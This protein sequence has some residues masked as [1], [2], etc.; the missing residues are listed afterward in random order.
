[1]KFS[2]PPIGSSFKSLM[3][4][5][6]PLMALAGFGG[7][8]VGTGALG[9]QFIMEPKSIAWL[10]DYLPDHLQ[11]PLSPWDRPHTLEDI[12]KNLEKGDLKLGEWIELSGGDRMTTVSQPRFNCISAC[13]RIIE[14][15]IY[16]RSKAHGP[17][18]NLPHFRMIA[19]VSIPSSDDRVILDSLQAANTAGLEIEED[20]PLD[21]LEKLET[22]ENQKGIWLNLLGKRNQGDHSVSYGQLFHYDSDRAKLTALIQWASPATMPLQWKKIT[23]KDNPQLLIDHTIGLEPRFQLYNLAKTNG[24]PEL[25]VI[26][27]AKPALKNS[28]FQQAINLAQ[29]GLWSIAADR[30]KA[31]KSG[32]RTWSTA[33]QAQFD[34]ITYHA[35][36]SQAQTQQTWNNPTQL[37]VAQLLD[38]QWQ[39]AIEVVTKDSQNAIEIREG[40]ASEMPRFW[41]R[42]NVA[43]QDD[44]GNPYLQAW[45]ARMKLDR[46]GKTKAIT[47]LNQQGSSSTRTTSLELLAPELLPTQ[48]KAKKSSDSDNPKLDPALQAPTRFNTQPQPSP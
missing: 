5:L 2:L 7:M 17:K 22:P 16:R 32:G 21:T 27:L 39:K 48:S 30:L 1:M 37:I 34:L 15:R 47:W 41:K 29:V 40:I 36:I 13:D 44:P 33:A 18:R 24:T 3:S 9:Y 4:H 26:S 20:L 45:I 10:N 42:L 35:K 8:V 46:D 11:I 14:L 28:E 6:L 23:G 12:K 43:I 19:Q 38:G 25:T 31:I